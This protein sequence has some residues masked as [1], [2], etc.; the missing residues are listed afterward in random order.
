MKNIQ[1]FWI[2]VSFLNKHL[3]FINRNKI[4]F[5]NPYFIK[6]QL[7]LKEYCIQL[8]NIFKHKIMYGLTS[9]SWG[10][11]MQIIMPWNVMVK[12]AKKS[13]SDLIIS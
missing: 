7:A 1:Q 9:N 13:Y 2:L 6:M 10:N 11:N 3:A 12:N 8:M 4:V 5:Q